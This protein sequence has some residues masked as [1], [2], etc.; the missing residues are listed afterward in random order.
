MSRDKI[1]GG[2]PSENIGGGGGNWEQRWHWEVVI[3]WIK[4]LALI[5]WK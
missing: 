5:Y 3:I 4:S 2:G 1:L